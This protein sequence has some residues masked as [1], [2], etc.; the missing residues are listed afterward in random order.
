M[1]ANNAGAGRVEIPSFELKVRR[2][3]TEDP[4]GF[5]QS[6]E[7][8]LRYLRLSVNDSHFGQVVSVKRI[9]LERL[10]P[11]EIVWHVTDLVHVVLVDE[12]VGF[13]VDGHNLAAHAN[14]RACLVC[15]ELHAVEGLFLRVVL[16]L[17]EESQVRERLSEA[18]F[19]A[20]DGLD[21]GEAGVDCSYCAKQ[22]QCK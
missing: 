10:A 22:H 11:T 19:S 6:F 12:L 7:H 8:H 9:E 2:L 14:K 20:E 3:R 13:L 4:F 16:V 15:A 17:V 5:I 1:E 21:L 18:I